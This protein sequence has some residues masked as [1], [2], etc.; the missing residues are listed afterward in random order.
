MTKRVM[1]AAVRHET[2]TF[3]QM[4][5]DVAAFRAREL[6][7]GDEIRRILAGTKTE[8]A[9]YLDAAERFGWTPVCP[10]SANATPSGKVTRAAFDEFAA[11]IIAAIDDN[12][13]FDAILLALHGAMVVEHHE[14]GEGQLLRLIRDRVGAAVPIGVT[15]D[16]HANVTDLMAEC[17]DVMISYRTYPHVDQYERAGETADLIRRTLE[18]E[19]HPTVTVA[20]TNV[21]DGVDHGRTTSPGPMT[22]VLAMADAMMADNTAVLAVSINAGFPW[23]D[24]RDAGPTAV[25]VCDGQ[26]ADSRAIADKLMDGAWE[27]RHRRTILSVT[28]VD[29]LAQA[30]QA[31]GSG[32]PIVFGDF[33]DNPGGGGYGDST[34]L[35][36]AMIDAGLDNAAFA[37]ICDA[38]AAAI[39]TKAGTGATVSLALGGKVDPRYGAPLNVTGTIEAITDGTFKYQGPMLAGS[40]LRMGPTAVLRVGGVDIVVT[41]TNHQAL[42]WQFFLHA[43]IDPTAK[44]VL[45]VKSAHHF[46]A[47]FGPVARQL[48]VVD[49]GGGLTSNDFRAFHYERVRR[50]IYPL[51]LD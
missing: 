35:L 27:S 5:T 42:D 14:D 38:E 17:A 49:S 15:L 44:S 31:D 12:P 50:P 29:A 51:D 20:R 10:V 6:Y 24:I 8:I 23:A 26:G 46:R 22:E 1:I 7:R 36:G 19:I 21:L 4:P 48:V 37:T 16:L 25:V 33:A 39:C 11:D 9:A 40:T 2:N 13:P 28:A 34:T 45:A 3:S 32:G 41:S 43:G 47:A 30:K 18:G